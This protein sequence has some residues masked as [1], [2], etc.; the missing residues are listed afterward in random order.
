MRKTLITGGSGDIGSLLYKQLRESGHEV[1]HF[2]RN[3]D[4]RADRILHLA[5]KSLPASTS[6]II[7]SNV[8]YLKDVAEYAERNGIKEMVFF[9]AISA[10]GSQDKE[11]L[12]EED[13]S[14]R[15]TFYDISKLLGEE[16]L[17]N[18]SLNVLCIRFPAILGLRNTTNLMAR[19]YLK[20]K[21]DE[22][23]RLTNPDKQFNNFIAV[24]NICE[25][26]AGLNLA[27]KFDVINLA[28]GREM[29]LCQVVEYMRGL[30]GSAS[31]IIRLDS[32]RNFFN[33]ST[34]KAESEYGFK[35]Q[36]PREVIS[37]WISQKQKY[38][39]NISSKESIR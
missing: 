2:D 37:R 26:L 38:E 1:E 34:K 19:F 32:W 11:N 3:A 13:S 12:S 39:K 4:V 16:L 24:E 6:Q 23:V 31:E 7:D 35:P 15:P 28:S 14:V 18:T 8:L 10:Y 33:I 29:T 22:P 27:K 20:L 36:D 25:F 30:M 9:S 5:A 17:K 21:D